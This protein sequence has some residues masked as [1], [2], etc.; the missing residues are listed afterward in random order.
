VLR[1]NLGVTFLPADQLTSEWAELWNG[2]PVLVGPHPTMR[3]EPVSGRDP[4]IWNERGVGWIFH[5]RV[6]QESA[7]VRRLVGEVWLDESRAAVVPGFQAV[8]DRVTSGQPVELSTGFP[9][10]TESQVGQFEGE[11]F[12]M[13]M[14]PAGADHLVI[15][16]EMTG[17]CAVSDGCGLGA[18][19]C[20]CQSCKNKEQ[21]PVAENTK[22]KENGVRG[23]W[24]RIT[25]LISAPATPAVLS[26]EEHNARL[27]QRELEALNL[28]MTDDERRQLL[29]ESLQAQH[30]GQDREVMLADVNSEDRW[31]IFWLLTPLGPM[32][33][34]AEYFK[35]M[36]TENEG[37]QVTFADPTRV[38]RLTRYEPVANS[39]GPEAAVVSAGNATPCKE[40]APMS[41]Q[42]NNKLAE[43]VGSLVLAVQALTTKVTAI[44]TAAKA[45]PNP[46]IA[47]LKGQ[48][49]TLTDEFSR[50]REVT[51]QAVAERERERQDLVKQLAGH[52]RVPFTAAELEAKPISELRK[53]A[54]M[55]A[56]ANFSGRGG[57]QGGPDAEQRFVEPVSPWQ[58]K[59]DGKEGGK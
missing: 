29:R 23:V 3:G 25:E 33:K 8:L 19:E 34:G 55:A 51:E 52:F 42:D 30:G 24:A 10:Q 1:N 12:E 32:P 43:Q 44:E 18:N 36:F 7:T 9:T 4:V 16:T 20:G 59:Q 13:V 27:V 58:G 45:D 39:A 50:M 5:A 47:G 14:Y 35:S 41:E 54:Q 26:W 46:A 6:E 2:I 22:T 48:I 56:S 21:T 49:A 15:S 17:A 31:V 40:G 11:A 37:G 38:R 28:S 53:L 57:P